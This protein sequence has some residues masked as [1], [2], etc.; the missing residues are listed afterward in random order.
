MI[1]GLLL[2]APL[3]RQ[4]R[5]PAGADPASPRGDGWLRRLAHPAT[6][7]LGRPDPGPDRR[8]TLID[9]I[10]PVL[11]PLYTAA[12]GVR[13]ALARHPHLMTA[14][15]PASATVLKPTALGWLGEV[16]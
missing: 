7:P 1:A 15:P 9:A 5:D 11:G 3:C 16:P 10:L 4:P 2:S 13:L 14:D 6:D 8:G 12:R